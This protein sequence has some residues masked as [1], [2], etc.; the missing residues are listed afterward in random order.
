VRRLA[1]GGVDYL[2][3]D[4]LHI[5]YGNWRPIEQ[6]LMKAFPEMREKIWTALRPASPYYEE[7]RIQVEELAKRYGVEAE[8]L[9]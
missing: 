8:C 9:F 7:L 4:S 6:A 2:F 1:D 5:K 3:F